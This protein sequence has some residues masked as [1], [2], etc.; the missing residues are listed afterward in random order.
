MGSNPMRSTVLFQMT[1]YSSD[2]LCGIPMPYL[3]WTDHRVKCLY[4]FGHQGSHSW[5]KAL[6]KRR[7]KFNE[8]QNYD[9]D[10]EQFLLRMIKKIL[11]D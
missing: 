9:P 8:S 5:E 10:H 2:G 3:L 1:D 7:G 4:E 11:D 6:N